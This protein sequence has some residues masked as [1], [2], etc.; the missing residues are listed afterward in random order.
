[1]NCDLITLPWD[2]VLSIF[3]SS[4]AN[5]EETRANLEAIVHRFLKLPNNNSY[6]GYSFSNPPT[7]IT[8]EEV[9]ALFKFCISNNSITTLE[10]KNISTLL[11]HIAAFDFVHFTDVMF[12]SLIESTHYGVKL[13]ASNVIGKILDPTTG[14]LRYAPLSPRNGFKKKDNFIFFGSD[15][16]DLNTPFGKSLEKIR[17]FVFSKINDIFSLKSYGIKR[18]S[19]PD[20]QVPSVLTLYQSTMVPFSFRNHSYA[21]GYEGKYANLFILSHFRDIRNYSN[22]MAKMR[23]TESMENMD[24]IGSRVSGFDPIK[25]MDDISNAGK[26]L[27]EKDFLM[28]LLKLIPLCNRKF[29]IQKD[30]GAKLMKEIVTNST[31]E[32]SFYL[33]WT[34]LMILVDPNFA[35]SVVNSYLVLDT[36]HEICCCQL[37]NLI[38]ATMRIFDVLCSVYRNHVSIDQFINV[39]SLGYYGFASNSRHVRQASIKLLRCASKFITDNRIPKIGVFI[40]TNHN[41]LARK[42]IQLL[43]SD[44]SSLLPS[45]LPSTIELMK[46]NKLVE[47]PDENLWQLYVI[48]VSSFGKEEFHTV[49]INR[50]K[51]FVLSKI[52]NGG[53]TSSCDHQALFN[54]LSILASIIN[55]NDEEITQLLFKFASYHLTTNYNSIKIVFRALPPNS[56]EYF[57]E[58]M[59]SCYDY[60]I[61]SV[62][63][64]SIAWTPD[65]INIATSNEEFFNSFCN[66]FLKLTESLITEKILTVDIDEEKINQ[67]LNLLTEYVTTALRVFLVL[68]V[69]Y[70]RPCKAPF[71]CCPCVQDTTIPEIS[72]FGMLL[73][74]V[75]RIASLP[76]C[77]DKLKS[78]SIRLISKYLACNTLDQ[79]LIEKPDFLELIHNYMSISPHI[80]LN[81]LTQHFSQMFPQYLQRAI[82]PN[83]ELYMESIINYFSESSLSNDKSVKEIILHQWKRESVISHDSPYIEHLQVITENCGTFF[84]ACLLYIIHETTSLTEKSFL[85]LAVIAPL[86]T[87]YHAKSHSEHISNI[88]NGLL[89]ITTKYGDTLASHDLQA[90]IQ[91]SQLLC[92]NC[93]FCVEQVIRDVYNILPQYPIQL[94]E[95]IL[96]VVMPW[97]RIIEFDIENRVICKDTELMFMNFT[98]F[99]FIEEALNTFSHFSKVDMNSPIYTVWKAFLIDENDEPNQNMNAVLIILFS[100]FNLKKY[101]DSLSCLLKYLYRLDQETIVGI[102]TSSLRFNFF[103][104]EAQQN[105]FF[106]GK[107]N[108]HLF[109]INCLYL[110]AL[111]SIRPI[112]EHLPIIFS[113]SIIFID[114]F[115]QI[116]QLLNRIVD[117]LML[118]IPGDSLP[119]LKK[120][121]NIISH[122]QDIR[123]Y[124]L[125]VDLMNESTLKGFRRT[126]IAKAMKDF[127]NEYDTK[128]AEDFSLELLKWG[129]CSYDLIRAGF[130]LNCRPIILNSTV[131][132]LYARSLSRVVSC[133]KII[134]DSNGD[135]YP[136]SFYIRSLLFSLK[137]IAKNMYNDESVTPDSSIFW[138]AMECLNYENTLVFNEA[139]KVIKFFLKRPQLFEHMANIAPFNG[140][141]FTSYIFWKYHSQWNEK[142]Q[143]CCPV[144]FS[145]ITDTKS[146][147]QSIVILNLIVQSRYMPLFYDSPHS[148]DI[149]ILALSPWF[150]QV[151]N[152][153]LVRFHMETTD[154]LMMN[155]TIEAFKSLITD[156]EVLKIIHDDFTPE[157]D[158]DLI[159]Y[160]VCNRVIE[161][162][163]KDDLRLVLKFYANHIRFGFKFMKIALLSL[164]SQIIEKYPD[165]AAEVTEYTNDI[166]MVQVENKKIAKFMPKVSLTREKNLFKKKAFPSFIIFDHIV[167]VEVPHLYEM[168]NAD[169]LLDEAEDVNSKLNAFPHMLPHDEV[170]LTDPQIEML[171][172]NLKQVVIQPYETW[173]ATIGK[174]QT[175]LLDPLALQILKQAEKHEEIEVSELL[176]QILV[177]IQ[178]DETARSVKLELQSMHD[179]KEAE[180]LA[181]DPFELVSLNIFNTFVPS[182]EESNIIGDDLFDSCMNSESYDY[183]LDI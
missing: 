1:M 31:I 30:L 79:E 162:I 64:N 53:A 177:Q 176:N 98:C 51:T 168:N 175:S 77:D 43:D 113:Y 139:L 160:R 103:F 16:S 91:I 119:A 81:L 7:D 145:Q 89:E 99:S 135:L 180:Q 173:S 50:F 109:S 49:A 46:F 71:P 18:N 33:F 74:P 72:Q 114:V 75:L 155:S 35:L 151:V 42:V 67:N 69:K 47:T 62:V 136:Y 104:F 39:N 34:Q 78:Y 93:R 124:A 82:L 70:T 133:A 24:D 115:E 140:T 84:N 111:D 120:L 134:Y 21:C 101:H 154:M 179:E 86:I 123:Q 116:P 6:P 129:L 2:Q 153:D 90:A 45:H 44:P 141:Q 150:W 40:D 143:G 92:D 118:V 12:Q 132:G 146:A 181:K 159:M 10:P 19:S 100:L 66:L 68:D 126:D 38:H 32:S 57:I 65:F 164:I 37:Y 127:L 22:K 60:K 17:A 106:N 5:F 23:S 20:L 9:D 25:S 52:P 171:N 36:I 83:G 152:I 105:E 112:I 76:A 178:N 11:T 163:D 59:T 165:M 161:I 128:Y 61:N 148:A 110:L 174:L 144:L 15:S 41:R 54:I 27:A 137:Y 63:M 169:D 167:V 142:Y 156:E 170:L 55:S 108:L 182:I 122:I 131:I 138:I 85:I 3:S 183:T 80:L 166:A 149:A 97:F 117:K 56:F 125:N 130:A 147:L 4:L 158:V 87:L 172:E 26:I 94:A 157:T 95:H 107:T 29:P 48:A 13:I 102:L 8:I 121:R 14:F 96:N 88:I 73:K 58:Y 28:Q